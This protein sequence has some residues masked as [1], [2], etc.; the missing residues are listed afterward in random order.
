MHKRTN[1]VSW[2]GNILLPT[3]DKSGR[4]DCND[5]V[6]G[7]LGILTFSLAGCVADLGL[8]CAGGR[9]WRVELS[10]DALKEPSPK[11]FECTCWQ[12]PDIK[13]S[14]F[15]TTL[16]QTEVPYPTFMEVRLNRRM[17]KKFVGS[18]LLAVGRGWSEIA[19]RW[20]HGFSCVPLTSATKF[21]DGRVCSD[22]WKL[23]LVD[24]LFKSSPRWRPTACIKTVSQ[25][26]ET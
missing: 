11:S 5:S 6:C 3:W 21:S 24:P 14:E 12:L 22:S 1:C 4:M 23:L 18:P 8:T 25:D 15:I 20:G 9:H 2:L 10:C 17:C 16:K 13:V 7:T 26:V 19:T